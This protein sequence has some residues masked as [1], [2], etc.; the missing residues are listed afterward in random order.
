MFQQDLPSQD[1]QQTARNIVLRQLAAAPKSRHQ[2]TKKLIERE[3]PDDVIEEVLDRFEAVDLIDD[4]SYA[5]MWVR[6]RHRSKGLARRALRM[7]LKQRGIKDHEAVTA[8][9]QVTDEDE[10][11]KAHEL[12]TKKLS[13]ATVPSSTDPDERK[14]R[15]RMVRRLVGMLSRK[16]YPPGLAF[17]VVTDAINTDDIDYL[18]E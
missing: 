8:L 11:T 1:D 6:S 5:Q 16:G 18:D 12:V 17:S 13:R 9:E 3:I 14:L 7:E 4:A 10:W 2:L 15:D